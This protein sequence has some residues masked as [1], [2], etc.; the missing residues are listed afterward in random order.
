[1]YSRFFF[2]HELLVDEEESAIR[3]HNQVAEDFVCALD[4]FALD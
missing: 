1:V 3:E 2:G 4:C